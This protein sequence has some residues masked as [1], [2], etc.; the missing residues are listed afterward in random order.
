LLISRGD[1]DSSFIA[2]EGDIYLNPARVPP[3]YRGASGFWSLALRR[4]NLINSL[5]Y[6]VMLR[7]A[8]FVTIAIAALS[9]TVPTFSERRENHKVIISGIS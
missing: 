1:F 7:F 4:F 5:I 8:A 3:S 2:L 6:S 9:L